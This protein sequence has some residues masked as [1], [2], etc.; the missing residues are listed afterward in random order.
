LVPVTALIWGIVLLGEEIRLAQY[1]G[2]VVVLFG[3]ALTT[4]IFQRISKRFSAQ[5]A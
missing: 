3:T 1:V 4:G 2:S 5:Q